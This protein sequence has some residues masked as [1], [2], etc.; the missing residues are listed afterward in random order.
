MRRILANLEIAKEVTL[1]NSTTIAGSTS[2]GKDAS[3]KNRALNQA[4]NSSNAGV[5]LAAA[6]V[7]LGA[8]GVGAGLNFGGSLI[9]NSLATNLKASVTPTPKKEHQPAPSNR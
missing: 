1:I 5:N 2:M 8:A 9:A 3:L 7:A 4:G 6:A